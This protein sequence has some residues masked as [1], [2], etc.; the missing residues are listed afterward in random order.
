VNK[1]DHHNALAERLEANATKTKNAHLKDIYVDLAVYHRKQ[2]AA[3]DA[4]TDKEYK[5]FKAKHP[6]M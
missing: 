6:D 5:T 2:V 4:K 3:I 1:R